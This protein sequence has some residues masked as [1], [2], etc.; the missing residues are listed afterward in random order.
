MARELRLFPDVI[1]AGPRFEERRDVGLSIVDGVI[2]EIAAADALRSRAGDAEVIELPGQAVMAGFVNAHQ[3]GR[4]MTQFQLGHADG[5]LETWIARVRSSGMLDPYRQTLLGCLDMIA[6]GITGAIHANTAYGSGDPVGDVRET[7]RAYA[8]SGLRAAVGLGLWDRAGYVYPSERE[9]AFVASLPP[10]LVARLQARRRPSFCATPQ[11]AK[12]AM[13]ML[14]GESETDRVK[15][16]YAPAGPQ[17]VSDE[18]MG[19]ALRDAADLGCIVHTHVLESW[20][21]Y[22]TLSELCPEGVLAHLARL[23]PVDGRLS[24][25]HAVWLSARDADMAAERGVTMVRNAGSNL[26]LECGAAPLAEYR[27]RGVRVAIG[28]DSFSL[29][30]DEDMLKEARLAGRLA[31]DRRWLRAPPPEPADMLQMMTAAGASA[32]GFGA[33]AGVLAQGAPADLVAIDIV[34]PRGA[35]T[36]PATPLADLIYYRADARDV[37][38]TMV[39]GEVLYRDGRHLRHDYAAVAAQAAD[40]VAQAAASVSPESRADVTTLV[41]HIHE[42]Y[43]AFAR[44]AVTREPPWR[45]LALDHC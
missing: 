14:R 21:Q 5:V 32:A 2:A 43:E 24:F 6:C 17:W 19:A 27:R 29:A 4:G 13:R 3:H 18:L 37:R 30:E 33:A 41:G 23:G 42:H 45:P 7:M 38:L 16:A 22:L 39:A 20:A 28:T 44:E 8:G 34:R 9:P 12:A 25:G 1:L 40:D 36:A 35:S 31:R 26:R 11:E 15:A 10:S